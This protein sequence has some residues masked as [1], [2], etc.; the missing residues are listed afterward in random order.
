MFIN[1]ADKLF[2]CL[3]IKIVNMRNKKIKKVHLHS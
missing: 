2:I 1:Y 3:I